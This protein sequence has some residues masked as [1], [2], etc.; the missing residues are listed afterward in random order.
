MAPRSSIRPTSAPISGNSVSTA[1]APEKV[2]NF[3]DLVIVRFVFSPDGKTVIVSRGTLTR[4]AFLLTN[5][6]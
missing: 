2:T 4:D 1:G 5:F 6:R 3:A